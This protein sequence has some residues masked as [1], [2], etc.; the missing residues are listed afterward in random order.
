MQIKGCTSKER[1][2]SNGRVNRKKSKKHGRDEHLNEN[3][4]CMIQF[5]NKQ[6]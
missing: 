2:G 5:F 4:E 6:P 3:V 1:Q